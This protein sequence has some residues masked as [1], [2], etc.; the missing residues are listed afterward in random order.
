MTGAG[1]PAGI[2]H[3]AIR[4]GGPAPPTSPRSTGVTRAPGRVDYTSLWTKGDVVVFP[5]VSGSV[6]DIDGAVNVA[7]DELF[8]IST[9]ASTSTTRSRS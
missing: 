6:S 1:G 8:S 4:S 3:V 5:Q 7:L 9:T 2:H